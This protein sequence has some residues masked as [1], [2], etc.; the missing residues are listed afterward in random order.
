[1][2]LALLPP[3]MWLVFGTGV[4]LVLVEITPGGY[5][6]IGEGWYYCIRY[7]TGGVCCVGGG[8]VLLSSHPAGIFSFNTSTTR[9][10][11]VYAQLVVHMLSSP[12][13]GLSKCCVGFFFFFFWL[14]TI[15]LVFF[16]NYK[17]EEFIQVFF[18]GKIKI[19]DLWAFGV[20]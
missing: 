2:Y 14:I 5:F 18:K 4:R 15:C 12:N 3:P 16:F 1:M 9:M 17:S 10:S 6:D 20:L 11:M 8:L 13:I 19:K 7:R